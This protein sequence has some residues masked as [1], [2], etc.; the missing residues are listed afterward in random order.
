MLLELVVEG[1]S[2]SD[3]SDA[4]GPSATSS[5]AAADSPERGE[6]IGDINELEDAPSD[7][8]SATQ[9]VIEAFPG[10]EVVEN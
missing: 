7:D 3:G 9:R 10:A 5:P 6:D 8:R 1:G 4:S 2:G